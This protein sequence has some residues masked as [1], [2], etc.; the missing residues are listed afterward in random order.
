MKNSS[1]Y[2]LNPGQIQQFHQQ[3]YLAVGPLVSVERLAALREAFQGLQQQ[4]AME[5]GVSLH[6][7]QRVLSQWTNLWKQHPLFAEQIRFPAI[8]H[9]ARQLLGVEHIQL[10]HDH[11]IAKPPC[12]SHQVPWHQDYA[13]WPVDKPCAL[14]AWLALDDVSADSGAL[15]FIPGQ[16]PEGERQDF[17]GESKDWGERISELQTVPVP[18]GWVIFHS[19]LSWH[20]SPPN[21]TNNPRRAFICI[22]MDSDC[23]WAPEHS[24]W[25]PTNE[26]INVAVGERFNQDKF[27]LVL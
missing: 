12:Y 11:L 23:R 26:D 4:W 9:I 15:Q 2:Q 16:H 14:S 13:Y 18:A 27:P 20:T 17:M 19:C 5:M 25:H 24:E 8:T 22:Y 21:Q 1:D 10:F 6:D 7:Y 3:S